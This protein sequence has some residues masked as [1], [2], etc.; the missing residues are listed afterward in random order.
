MIAPIRP[1]TRSISNHPKEQ[2]V[3]RARRLIAERLFSA[4]A[5][6]RESIILHWGRR[7]LAVWILFVLA[8]YSLSMIRGR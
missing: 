5:V 6:P 3:R 2:A 8:Y 1:V 7:I 4:K